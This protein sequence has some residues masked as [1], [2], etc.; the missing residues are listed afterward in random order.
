MA[1][2]RTAHPYFLYDAIQ[3]QPDLIEQVFGKQ[4]AAIEEAAAAS[5]GRKRFVF[6]GIG[7]SLNA[8]NISERW[9]RF[10]SG[11]RAVARAEESFEFALSPLALGAEDV[12]IVITH[13]GTTSKSV[14]ALRTAR[15]G[16]ALTIAV[17][18]QKSGDGIQGADFHLET[19]EQEVAF[20]YTKSYT[21][22]LAALAKYVLA[23]LGERNLLKDAAGADAA[24]EKVPSLMRQALR[25]ELKIR[26]IAKQVA[27]KDRIVF[28]GSGTCWATANEAALKI[29][30]TSYI[31]A[32]G[33]ETEEILHGPFSEID[34]RA[35][36]V[37]MLTGDPGDDRARTVLRAGGEL[38]MLR[39]AITVPDANRDIA[40]DH[41][42]VLPATPP[43]LAPFVHLVPLQLL[44]YYIA[45]ARGFNPD[46]GRQDQEA[47]ARAH[48][49]YKL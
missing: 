47:H 12:A 42:I 33:F 37:T 10:H 21:T 9:M 26:E 23:I 44:T 22:A 13:T 35:V 31:A 11:G 24:L 39:V 43:W 48:K 8:A 49:V 15:Q 6:L 14:D 27:A 36:M 2:T 7:T 45:L 17:T 1:D 32:E 3:A 41:V 19:C 25:T 20:A 4:R 28:F 18:G 30:E 38:G 46:S 40:A 16:G 29:K 5:T 34:S